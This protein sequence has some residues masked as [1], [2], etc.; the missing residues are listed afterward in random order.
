MRKIQKYYFNMIEIALAMA[1][2][3]IGIS[4]ILVLFPVGINANKTAIA[5]NNLADVAEYMMGYLRGRMAAA[6]ANTL[7]ANMNQA[8]NNSFRSTLPSSYPT[9]GD[10]AIPGDISS[11]WTA[12]GNTAHGTRLYQLTANKGVFLFQQV[13]QI[14][15]PAAGSS[16]TIDV[17]D[18]SAIIKVWCDDTFD[19]QVF[20]LDSYTYANAQGI[21]GLNKYMT[22]L[23]MEFSWPAEAPYANRETRVFRFEIFNEFFN[24]AKES[25]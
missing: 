2:L 7:D 9:D 13:S 17:P 15:D 20:D 3:A 6:W 12:L 19:F 11:S 21:T 24:K 1:I 16:A 5:N 18:F 25:D 4:S 23:C 8:N 22:A 10:D 14:P